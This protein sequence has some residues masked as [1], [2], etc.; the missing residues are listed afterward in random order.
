VRAAPQE[1]LS[2]TAQVIDSD[3]AVSVRT[4]QV[5]AESADRAPK[6]RINIERLLLT[7][8]LC[9]ATAASAFAADIRVYSG[10][11]PK[12]ALAVIAPAFEKHSGHKVQF[13]FAVTSALEQKLAAGDRPDMVLMPLPVIDKLVETG[14]LR[15][16]PRATLGT[17]GIAMIVRRGAAAPDIST[18]D[19]LRQVLTEAR[20]I[21]HANP[22]DT[23]SGAH[24]ARMSEQLGIADAMQKKVVYRNALDGGVELIAKGE[25]EIGMYPVSEVISS[26]GVRAVGLL[27]EA[28][29]LA[30]VYGAA[31]H[32]QN[33]S[34]G[35]AGEFVEFLAN[36][37]NRKIWRN[38]G[39]E[40]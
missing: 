8:S 15:P 30:T 11:A 6:M 26:K 20:S 21:V 36:P 22:K 18:V 4:R 32:A 34:P 27:P 33:S 29:Q 16:E 12:E 39:F 19:R 9:A 35:P 7:L 37:V 1:I 40:N 2:P 17:V 28:V 23:P 14:T 3:P 5:A 25:A 38:A 31:V 13:T 24:L 10:G